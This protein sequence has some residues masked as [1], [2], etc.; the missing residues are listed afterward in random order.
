[1]GTPLRIR[2]LGLVFATVLARSLQ[3]QNTGKPKQG[4]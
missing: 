4:A 2:T 1:M 3:F